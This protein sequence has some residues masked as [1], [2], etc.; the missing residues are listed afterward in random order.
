MKSASTLARALRTKLALVVAAVAAVAAST[1]HDTKAADH[2]DPIELEPTPSHSNDPAADIADIFAWNDGV[3][4]RALLNLALTWRA[5]PSYERQFDPTI[6]FTIHVLVDDR[7]HDAA[8]DALLAVKYQKQKPKATH[9]IRIAFGPKGERVA[10]WRSATSFGVRVVGIPGHDRIVAPVGQIVQLDG[11]TPSARKVKLLAGVVDDAFFADKDGFFNGVS[12]PLG[13]TKLTPE[14]VQRFSTGDLADPV[15]GKV[16]GGK[17]GECNNPTSSWPNY[18][19]LAKTPFGLNNR[20]DGFGLAN[21]HGV[22]LQ[23]PAELLNLR[24]GGDFKKVHVWAT[25]EGLRGR[26]KSGTKLEVIQ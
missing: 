22:V 26:T 10:D 16:V 9:E 17:V 7:A 18:P 21:M 4:D 3:G 1:A 5:D 23:I 8:G 2:N 24:D 6:Q 11:R 20:L 19:L 25:S 12:V 15:P 14:C 13:N